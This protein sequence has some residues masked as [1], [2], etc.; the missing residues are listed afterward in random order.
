MPK[1]QQADFTSRSY[2]Y[3]FD[4]TTLNPVDASIESKQRHQKSAYYILT[5]RG[6]DIV[7]TVSVS[8]DH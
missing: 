5:S 2:A 6:S 1:Q 3:K 4:K 8:L 7:H